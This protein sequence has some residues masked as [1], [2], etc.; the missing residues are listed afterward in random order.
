ML[1]LC[2]I[3]SQTPI[4]ALCIL[5]RQPKI[6]EASSLRPDF[7]KK[8]G[9]LPPPN[10]YISEK[11]F[12]WRFRKGITYPY[13]RN[14]IYPEFSVHRNACAIC[15]TCSATEQTVSDQGVYN[16]GQ[17]SQRY[18]LPSPTHTSRKALFEGFPKRLTTPPPPTFGTPYSEKSADTGK[19]PVCSPVA[20]PPPPHENTPLPNSRWLHHTALRYVRRVQ[21]GAYTWRKGLNSVKTGSKW[22]QN[23]CSCTPNGPGSL[24][25]KH[26]FDP[27]WTH[28]CS[29]NGPFSRHFGIFHGPKPVPMG[30]KW[31]KNTCFSIPNVAFLA[32]FWAVPRTPPPVSFW[33]KTWIWQGHH[34]GSRMAKVESSPRE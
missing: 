13:L 31:A 12:S 3:L 30:S 10:P 26:I 2:P 25:E 20:P 23:T 14:N 9:V 24:L 15:A 22:A 7:R 16:H 27:F 28:F 18:G 1:E 17:F 34:L 8:Y 33:L 19:T 4:G 29:Q 32:P 11:P 21:L 6:P 5:Q